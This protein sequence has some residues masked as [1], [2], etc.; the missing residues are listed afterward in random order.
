MIKA[1]EPKKNCL[2]TDFTKSN[3]KLFLAIIA[4]LMLIKQI[5]IY[6]YIIYIYIYIYIFAAVKLTRNAKKES[7]F[8]MIKEMFLMILVC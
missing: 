5:Y 6:I 3:R 1:G 8:T 2:V 4:I 7:S